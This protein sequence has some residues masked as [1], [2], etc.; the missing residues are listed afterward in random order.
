MVEINDTLGP[1]GI[2]SMN[3]LFPP[4]N[5]VRARRAIL[6]AISQEEYM[7]AFVGTDEKL[8]KPMPSY[9]TPGARLYTEEGGDLLKGPRKLDAA[10]RLLAES[11]YAGQPVTLM[12]AQD[13]P[14]LKAWGDVTV[15]VLQ[16]LG[17]KAGRLSEQ[18]ADERS[19][20]RMRVDGAQD[21]SRREEPFEHRLGRTCAILN[22]DGPFHISL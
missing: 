19:R 8:W 2:L 22:E 11:G 15:D 18:R 16:R 10:R 5:D 21:R 4:F 1:I 17:M 14:P 7:H 20:R 12:A 9:F 13:S 3:H 6:A